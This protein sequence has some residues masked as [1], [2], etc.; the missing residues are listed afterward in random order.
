MKFRDSNHQPYKGG[1]PC[2]SLVSAWGAV[3]RGWQGLPTV[4]GTEEREMDPE[5]PGSGP[6]F[7][8]APLPP[9]HTQPYQ[10]TLLLATPGNPAACK[11]VAAP[12]LAV[13]PEQLIRNNWVSE[14]L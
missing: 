1:F 14:G 8:A 10:G 9:S 5:P 7:F 2:T 6:A 11:G 3:W 13:C 12:H 4:V